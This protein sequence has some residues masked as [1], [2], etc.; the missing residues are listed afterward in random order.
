MTAATVAVT[1][2]APVPAVPAEALI[3]LTKLSVAP[4]NVRRTDKRGGV[5]G[6]AESIAE[7]GLLQNLVVFETEAGR[8]RVVAGGR[9][10]AALKL[11]AKAGRWGGPVRC[12]VLPSEAAQRVSL[13]E[14]VMR[15]ALHPADEF[16]AFAAL[17]HEGHDAP[18]VARRFGTTVRHV[19]QRMKL[20]AVSP[21]LVKAYRAG[22][23]TLDQLTAFAV[24]DDHARQEQVWNTHYV[25]EST[26]QG[27]RRALLSEH[28]PVTDKL[29][30]FVT[31]EAYEQAGGVV[32]RDLFSDDEGGTWLADPDLLRR[33]AAE[34]MGAE[35]AALSAEGWGWVETFEQFPY[36]GFYNFGRVYPRALPLSAEDRAELAR[37]TER[38]DTILTSLEAAPD[39][40]LGEELA[41]VEAAIGA[42]R[43]RDYGFTPEDMAR[44][45]A[46]V[47]LTHEGRLKVE[48][49]LVRPED[50]RREKKERERA[51]RAEIAAARV[52][53]GETVTEAPFPAL[54]DVL[55]EEM[56]A[57]RTAALR[58][59]VMRRPDLALAGVVHALAM[60]VFYTHA[61]R[62]ESAFEIKAT[63]IDLVGRIAG[64]EA[65]PTLAAMT[66]AREAWGYRLPG[67]VG[68]LW[69]W[70]TEQSGD[71]LLDLLAYLAAQ[72][73]NG[74][75]QRH[76]RGRPGRVEHADTIA[77]SADLNMRTWWSVD[78][79]FLAR[80]SKAQ[81]A[82]AVAD[83]MGEEAG[84]LPPLLLKLPKAEAVS[85]AAQA[86]DGRGWLPELL[87]T[88]RQDGETEIRARASQRIAV[89]VIRNTDDVHPETVHAVAAE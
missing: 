6:L 8:F 7:E 88:T 78:A 82:A 89:D 63:S 45:G 15:R 70:L 18:E 24:V 17:M 84:D 67:D 32:T 52:E 27:I 43:Q 57:L 64:A 38:R 59:E 76:E 40:V 12:L 51:E 16:E 21:A 81:I 14:N 79:A 13:A 25:R 66:E 29:A 50:V 77:A 72:S 23:M 10:L 56:T 35:A 41:T 83:G 3:P 73:L 20:A 71:T 31:L 4:E 11:L 75:K 26:G 42:V 36:S 30:R 34:K 19:E 55:T 49:G 69:E 2:P 47:G 85:R 28:V 33:L 74:V 87:R 54:S 80:L 22:D 65:C 37:L 86:L 53:A 9:R 60:P 61:W 1:A 5:E 48:R 44:A 68:D 46:A 62:A 39:E 58:V